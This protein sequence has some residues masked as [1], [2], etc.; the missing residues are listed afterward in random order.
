M[1]KRSETELTASILNKKIKNTQEVK[2]NASFLDKTRQNVQIFEEVLFFKAT[3][4]TKI[5]N[6]HLFCQLDAWMLAEGKGQ[7]LWKRI[8]AFLHGQCHLATDV[9]QSFLKL[10]EAS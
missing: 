9:W 4:D 5:N 1:K 7:H 3:Y 10:C 8:V 6:L 2:K